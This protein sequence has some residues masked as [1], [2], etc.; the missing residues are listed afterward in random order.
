VLLIT[1]TNR[2][3][4]FAGVQAR[5]AVTEV[6]EHLE[7]VSGATLVGIDPVLSCKGAKKGGKN[8]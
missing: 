8:M 2:V 1:G 4:A 3:D 6:T 7:G 5:L